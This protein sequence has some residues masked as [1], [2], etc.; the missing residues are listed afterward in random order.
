[1]SSL[2]NDSSLHVCPHVDQLQKLIPTTSF[3]P[4]KKINS[5]IITDHGLNC[6]KEIA[7]KNSQLRFSSIKRY[8][9]TNLAFAAPF[10]IPIIPAASYIFFRGWKDTVVD[11]TT[12]AY[13]FGSN[14]VG[15]I[16]DTVAALSSSNKLIAGIFSV[17]TAT[18][19]VTGTVGGRPI[20]RTVQFV[21]AGLATLTFIALLNWAR[22]NADMVYKDY[23]RIED[24]LK[25]GIEKNYKKIHDHLLNIFNEDSNALMLTYGQLKDDPA[26]LYEFQK[27]LIPLNKKLP[28]FAKELVKLGLSSSDVS[29]ILYKFSESLKFILSK[30]LE[31]RN[32]TSE[33]NDKYNAKLLACMPPNQNISI[34]PNAKKHINLSKKYKLSLSFTVKRYLNST[35][36]G[37]SSTLALPLIAAAASFA[38]TPTYE[39]TT[40]QLLSAV[41]EGTTN[42]LSG[43]AIAAGAV[44]AVTALGVG[45]GIAKTMSDSYNKTKANSDQL[46]L[47]HSEQ[48]KQEILSF[49]NG[50]ANYFYKQIEAAKDDT[51]LLNTLKTE[52]AVIQTKLPEIHREIQKSGIEDFKPETATERL[53]TV[54]ENIGQEV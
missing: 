14:L 34:P 1:M 17:F 39:A 50:I 13:S 26:Q 46:R 29:N 25:K 45:L 33:D 32:P 37:I 18:N 41:K 30:K 49:Y 52:M 4:S 44:T 10:T 19:E 38:H 24:D 42:S 28:Y 43:S 35:L 54:L 22:N 31:A 20:T 6:L 36:S 16:S 53:R 47:K 21:A 51:H 11:T 48:A 5:D 40:G 2:N 12:V 15:T 7:E 8:T 23:I 27:Y 3:F 9:A